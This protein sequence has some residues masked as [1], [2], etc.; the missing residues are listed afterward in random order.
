[1][2][3]YDECSWCIFQGEDF[4]S[5]L[6]QGVCQGAITTVA[7]EHIFHEFSFEEMQNCYK[8]FR[9]F[10]LTELTIIK[11]ILCQVI[12]EKEEEYGKK[13]KD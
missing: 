1:M 7:I 13:R 4:S 3:Q 11:S 8:V 6:K 9:E 10:Q 2:K 5:C 12:R